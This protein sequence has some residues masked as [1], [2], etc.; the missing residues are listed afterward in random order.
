[1]LTDNALIVQLVI[2]LVVMAFAVMK[3]VYV[4]RENENT[5]RLLEES[6]RKR[7]YFETH[8]EHVTRRNREAFIGAQIMV[9]SNEDEPISLGVLVRFEAVSKAENPIPIV[10]IEGKEYLCMGAVF[11]YNEKILEEAKG[12][13]NKEQWERFKAI[14]MEWEWRMSESVKLFIVGTIFIVFVI[15]LL[16]VVT[17]VGKRQPIQAEVM[18]VDPTVTSN[19]FPLPKGFRAIGWDS[20]NNGSVLAENASDVQ[21]IF[22][23]NWKTN[24]TYGRIRIVNEEWNMTVGA[25]VGCN[26]KITTGSLCRECLKKIANYKQVYDALVEAESHLDYC[27]YGD[28]WER[29][30]A[31]H[32][33]LPEKLQAAIKAGEIWLTSIRASKSE[34]SIFWN[35][36][37]AGSC[38]RVLLATAPANTITVGMDASPIAVRVMARGKNDTNRESDLPFV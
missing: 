25:C 12:L 4:V 30:C 3:Y 8:L 14:S 13:S 19:I 36:P 37:L 11:P 33:N 7:I 18:P 28:S 5:K 9:R 38:D 1:M 26:T 34:K 17:E 27:G 21:M 16:T 23:Q 22:Y 20:H 29:E 24:T 2:A 32:D 31:R 35:I 15:S 10:E 6:E